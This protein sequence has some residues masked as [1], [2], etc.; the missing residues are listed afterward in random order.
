MSY[1]TRATSGWVRCDFVLRG[2]RILLRLEKTV[3]FFSHIER[4]VVPGCLVIPL[5]ASG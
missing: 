3:T 2:H 1:M 4:I 5:Q